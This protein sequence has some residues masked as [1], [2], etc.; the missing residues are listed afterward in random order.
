MVFKRRDKPP[1]FS[2]LREVLL[3]QKGWR[4]GIEYLGHRVR[5]LPD[6]PHRISLGLACGLFASFT[7][8]FGLHFILAVAFARV[9]RGNILAALIGTAFGNPLTFPFIASIAL[10]TGR[11][12]LGHAPGTSNFQ[13]LTKAF[14]EFFEVLWQSLLSLAGSGE[15]QWAKLT[16]FLQDVFWPYLVG[17]ILP[18]LIAAIACY[19]LCRPVVAAYQVRRRARLLARLRALEAKARDERD[20]KSDA[21][22]TNRYNGV[23]KTAAN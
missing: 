15:A 23:K 6:T 14:R 18:G 11:A 12:I 20:G 13:M 22:D 19:F 17:G 10:K 4:R 9:V 16:I 7:P 1:F 3:P 21:P 5:R 8:F 2:R